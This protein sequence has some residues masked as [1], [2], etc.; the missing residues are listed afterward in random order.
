MHAAPRGVERRVRG[1]VHHDAVA[2]TTHEVHH[3]A[4]RLDHVV[5]LTAVRGLG[6]PSVAALH[7]L[8][9]QRHEWRVPTRVPR[10][11]AEIAGVHNSA[12]RVEHDIGRAEV[13]VGDPRAD[14]ARRRSPLRARLGG[15]PVPVERLEGIVRVH[16]GHAV[17]LG[18]T[19]VPPP[20]MGSCVRRTVA[21]GGVRPLRGPCPPGRTTGVRSPGRRMPLPAP[22]PPWPRRA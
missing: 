17:N 11:V 5:V 13:H 19:V 9:E 6:C 18:D 15:E 1:G 4:H 20:R 7:A 3:L 12:Q 16:G 22:A 8:H 10:G 21:E 2:R 14:A